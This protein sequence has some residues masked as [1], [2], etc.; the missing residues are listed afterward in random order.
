M[1]LDGGLSLARRALEQA[2]VIVEHSVIPAHRLKHVSARGTV[3]RAFRSARGVRCGRA[4]LLRTR[5]G[6][7]RAVVVKL[8]VTVVTLTGS[9]VQLA[10]TV[11]RLIVVAA[12]RRVHGRTRGARARPVAAG[13]AARGVVVAVEA[14]AHALLV[15][16]ARVLQDQLGALVARILKMK[17]CKHFEKQSS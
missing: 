11:V 4:Q 7:A 8:Q 3:A 16:A 1:S 13:A 15:A 12:H 6:C 5:A 9:P 2:Q 10:L 17:M 14:R